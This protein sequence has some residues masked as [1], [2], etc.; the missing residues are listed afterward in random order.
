VT[1][2]IPVAILLAAF[3]AL[4]A[5]ADEPKPKLDKKP[6][7]KTP[8]IVPFELLT[9][10]HMA[11]Q[12]KINGKG[13]YR[14]VFDTGAPMNLINTKIAKDSGVLD[15]KA[16]KPAFGLFGAMGAHEAKSLEIGD[17]KM[18]KVGVVVMDHPTVAAISEALGP[19]DGIIGFP[20]FARYKMTVDYKKKELTL[21]P[22]GYVPGDYLQGMMDK[23]MDAS[24]QSKDPKVLAPAGL[25]GLV[26]DKDKDD[27]EAG[28]VVKDVLA[29]SAAAAAGLKAGDRIVTIDGRWTDTIPDAFLAATFIKP[30]KQAVVAVQREEKEIKL[31]VKPAKGL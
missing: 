13:P 4:P 2:Q 12:V 6:A 8:L 18:E 7:D 29:G 23:L 11:V 25:W 21:V 27:E 24:N 3:L 14:L 30:G 28:V 19:I 26:L 1:V 31:T 5:F 15:P 9:S 17:A 22:N 16:K 20:F 10:R